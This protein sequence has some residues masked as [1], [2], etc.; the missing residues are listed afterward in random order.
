MTTIITY[1]ENKIFEFIKDLST[2]LPQSTFTYEVLIEDDLP[3]IMLRWAGGNHILLQPNDKAVIADDDFYFESDK[4]LFSKTECKNGYFIRP[5][6]GLAVAE[7]TPDVNPDTLQNNIN[8]FP[9]VGVARLFNSYNLLQR[10]M[11]KLSLENR[12]MK[13]DWKRPDQ[14]KYFIDFDANT[15]K[16]EVCSTHTFFNPNTVYFIDKQTAEQ[17][18]DLFNAHIEDLLNTNLNTLLED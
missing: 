9:S 13:I 4:V 6:G 18:L 11:L 5:T 7:Y 10:K 2:A 1:S 12:G 8:L 3:L 17:A 15:W 14:P 16:G